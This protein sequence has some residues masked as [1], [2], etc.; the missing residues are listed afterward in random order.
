MPAK[1][2]LPAGTKFGRLTVLYE[3][4]QHDLSG[5]HYIVCRCRCGQTTSVLSS[6]LR[7]GHTRSC[8]CLTAEAMRKHRKA[9]PG[10]D[11]GFARLNDDT[12]REI[13][14]LYAAGHFQSELA[15]DFNTC[16]TNIS[17]I[18]RRKAWAHVQ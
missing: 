11:N 7:R 13:R 12:I 10:T 15:R 14:A 3:S 5:S 4:Q 17:L 16:P 1:I 6:N 8:G 2:N 18:V 9:R